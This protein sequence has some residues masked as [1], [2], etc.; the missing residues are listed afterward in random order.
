MNKEVSLEEIIDLIVEALEDGR[1]VSFTPHGTSM[2]PMLHNGT[3]TVFLKKPSDKL[4]RFD[5]VLY[6]RTNGSYVLHRI[7]KINPDGCYVLCGDNQL[8]LESGISDAQIIAVMTSFV[9]N[10]KQY[11]VNSFKY[12]A[13]VYFWYY[14]RIFRR[15]FNH[16]IRKFKKI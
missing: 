14:T 9:R 10:G 3:D 2:L 13:Y 4:K 7:V 1:E 8:A 6:R 12:K 15:I 11:S 5:I 16:F